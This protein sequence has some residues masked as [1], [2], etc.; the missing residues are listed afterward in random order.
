MN[1]D[2]RSGIARIAESLVY[3]FLIFVCVYFAYGA[4]QGNNGLNR[5]VQLRDQLTHLQREHEEIQAEV[6]F[7]RNK[8]RRISDDYLDLEL[9]DEMTRKLL[10]YVRSDE[11]IV[12]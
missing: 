6:E 10:G 11:V 2:K 9:L 5:Q 4:I 1:T 3:G 8:T 7:L 12:D